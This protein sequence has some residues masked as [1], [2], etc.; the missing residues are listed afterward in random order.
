MSRL[1]QHE[2][3][4]TFFGFAHDGQD[5]SGRKFPANSL[6][7]LGHT[8]LFLLPL[9]IKRISLKKLKVPC[10]PCSQN[11][12]CEIWAGIAGFSPESRKVP[13]KFPVNWRTERICPEFRRKN[14]SGTALKLSPK[15]LRERRLFRSD[16]VSAAVLVPAFFVG[17]SA[18]GLLLAY[19]VRGNALPVDALRYERLLHGFGSARA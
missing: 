12:N 10:N 4:V 8:A 11:Q 19:A 17:I 5:H 1:C 9:C 14:K 7:I 6:L 13:V 16:E 18:E 2:V 3:A 15:P